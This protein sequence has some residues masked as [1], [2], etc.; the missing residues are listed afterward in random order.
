MHRRADALDTL[1]LVVILEVAL[2]KDEV[3]RARG[4]A[5]QTRDVLPVFPFAGILVTGDYRPLF[6]IDA[7]HWKVYFRRGY[8]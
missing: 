2:G 5:D 1:V 4:G 6:R 3:E 8:A 7:R